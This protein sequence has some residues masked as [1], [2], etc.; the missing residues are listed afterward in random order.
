MVWNAL[1]YPSCVFPVTF[2]DQAVDKIAPPHEFY[3]E[4]DKN[5]YDLY[6][7]EDFSGLPIGLQLVGCRHE[8]EA[9]IGMTEVVFTALCKRKQ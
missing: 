1:D 5:H 7:P 3:D 2:V 8:D 6:K 4:A 9:V